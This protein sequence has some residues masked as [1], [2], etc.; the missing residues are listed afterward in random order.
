MEHQQRGTG[1]GSQR[2]EMSNTLTY[3]DLGQILSNL[4]SKLADYR[5]KEANA[6]A[7]FNEFKQV[8]ERLQSGIYRYDVKTHRFHFFNRSIIELLGSKGA[9]AS[10]I[11][12]KSVLL[13]LHPDDRE[14]VRREAK[15]ALERGIGEV[16]YRFKKS[17]GTYR[18]LYDRWVVL[19]DLGNQPRYIE[20]IVM[21]TTR[22]KVA[23][24]KL[25]ESER[26]LRSLSSH[27]LDAQEKNGAVSPWNS[28]MNWAKTS[29]S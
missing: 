21:D 28:T 24:E 8:A 1:T 18:W 7:I 5:K 13:R 9:D 27:L 16:E 2:S 12:S 4:Q 6:L 22:R 11:T 19:R 14:R 15:E 10:E 23:E 29:P 3:D 25:K 26:N 20:G 17:D